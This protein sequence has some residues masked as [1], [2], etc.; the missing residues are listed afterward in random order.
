M[1]KTMGW[2]DSLTVTDEAGMS[3]NLGSVQPV[4]AGISANLSHS[5][6]KAHVASGTVNVTVKP[7]EVGWI[8]R[9]PLMHK[10]TGEWT[11]HYF[12]PVHG[13]RH[14]KIAGTILGPVENGTAG[15]YSAVMVKTR[16]M[17]K[18]EIAACA[19]RHKPKQKAD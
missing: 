12:F 10:A 19:S 16:P 11:T 2:E 15:K 17:T 13:R 8:A 4:A 6:A 5:K 18:K 7:R 3:L 14:W 1:A 9:A